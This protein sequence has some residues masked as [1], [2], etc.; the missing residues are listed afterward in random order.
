MVFSK[1]ILKHVDLSTTCNHKSGIILSEF[2]FI[3]GSF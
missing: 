2:T 1:D 3:Y